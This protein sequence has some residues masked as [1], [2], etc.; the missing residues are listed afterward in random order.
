MRR[1]MTEKNLIERASA[2]L[3]KKMGLEKTFLPDVNRV[4]AF[5]NRIFQLAILEGLQNP[6]QAELVA[7]WGFAL[8]Q[9]YKRVE[10]VFSK[11]FSPAQNTLLQLEK[12]LAQT[13]K[14]RM[15][16]IVRTSLEEMNLARSQAIELLVEEKIEPTP[17][18]VSR[19]GTGLLRR[20]HR[21]RRGNIVTTETQTSAEMTKGILSSEDSEGEKTWITVR[22]GNVRTSHIFA[23]NQKRSISVP[24]EVGGFSLRWPGDSSLGAPVRQVAYCRCGAIYR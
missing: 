4:F 18:I 10:Q 6:N 24:F 21:G 5:E 23:H 14:Q 16:K 7:V 3:K 11:D 12:E 19:I 17:K 9:H 8:A 15:S 22:D 20:K 2:D 13:K 1:A